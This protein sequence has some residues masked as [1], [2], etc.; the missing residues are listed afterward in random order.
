[1]RKVTKGMVTMLGTILTLGQ[2]VV[3][4]ED[5]VETVQFTEL[6]DG[7]PNEMFIINYVSGNHIMFDPQ[8]LST[9]S[10]DDYAAKLRSDYQKIKARNEETEKSLAAYWDG[11]EEQ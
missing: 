6:Q 4:N 11:V 5:T 9:L 7:N 2:S 3:G 1:M 8:L 10:N